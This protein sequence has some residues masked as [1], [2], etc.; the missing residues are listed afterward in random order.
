MIKLL[1]LDIDGTITEK[2]RSIK[3]ETLI[4]LRN[5]KKSMPEITICLVS[6]NVLPVMYGIRGIMGVGDILF[7]ENGGILMRDG[8]IEKFFEP[9]ITKRAFQKI[10]EETGAKE[11][12]TNRWRETSV[13]FIPGEKT[14]YTKYEKEFDVRIEDSGFAVHIMNQG[15]NKGF[16]VTKLIDIL[17]IKK[18][19]ILAC[20][21]GDNDISMF[22]SV[23]FSGCPSNASAGLKAESLYI[24]EK[25]YGDGLRDILEH[26]SLL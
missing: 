1:V 21:D 11:Y 17:N 12:I 10:K 2:D 13:A 7:G 5:L 25:S 26:F 22:R 23:T 3:V 6:G 20:G 16:A 15:Q 14:N 8:A 24:S 19:E 4:S 18:D 9:G